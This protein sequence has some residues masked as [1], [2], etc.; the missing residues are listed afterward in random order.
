MYGIG[1]QRYVRVKINIVKKFVQGNIRI[2]LLF[3]VCDIEAMANKK[4]GPRWSSK[5]TN[6]GQMTFI[7]FGIIDHY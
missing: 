5:I 6:K 4:G 1:I 2:P 7:L 3:F